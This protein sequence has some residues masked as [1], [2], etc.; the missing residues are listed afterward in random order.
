M[1]L[2]P[3]IIELLKSLF[4]SNEDYKEIMT[5]KYLCKLYEILKMM[6]HA[7]HCLDELNNAED[8][9]R[10]VTEEREIFR[11]IEKLPRIFTSSKCYKEYFKFLFGFLQYDK[12]KPHTEGHIKRT[13]LIIKN[14]IREHNLSSDFLKKIIPKLYK[15][16][17]DLIALRDSTLNAN[18]LWC[19]IGKFFVAIS[20]HFINPKAYKEDSELQGSDAEESKSSKIELSISEKV[21]EVVW[22]NTIKVAKEMLCIPKLFTENT[23]ESLINTKVA[24]K[25]VEELYIIII[26]FILNT[27]LP[28]SEVHS[29]EAPKELLS[30]IDT[31]CTSLYSL[32]LAP[33]SDAP[34]SRACVNT[35]ITL[36]DSQGGAGEKIGKAAS[37]VLVN[38]CKELVRSYVEGERGGEMWEW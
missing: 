31:T 25:Q 35:L 17:E 8:P 7:M 16:I 21:N 33:H 32:H 2:V 30:I 11:F 13:L 20:T 34:L 4:V 36:S 14:T 23:D 27:L 12:N 19:S 26:N 28:I 10:L 18:S 37:R 5:E 29:S 38:R 3:T 1:R 22:N 9:G 6:L 24:L 15:K